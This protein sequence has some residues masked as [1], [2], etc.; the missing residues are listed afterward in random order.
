MSKPTAQAA[1]IT[2]QQQLIAARASSDRVVECEALGS[3]GVV[4]YQGEQWQDA[5][6]TCT[7]YLNLAKR[8]G[9]QWQEGIA[10]YYLGYS[11][12]AIGELAQAVDAFCAA[13]LLSR[14]FG[15][16]DVFLPVWEQLN[17]IVE[18]YLSKKEFP[19]A[20][21]LTQWQLETAQKWDNLALQGWLW[22]K[23]GKVHYNSGNYPEAIAAHREMLAIAEALSDNRLKN[24]TWAWLGCS[25]RE[26]GELEPALTYFEKR[27]DVVQELQ[28]RVAQRETLDWLISIY[29]QLKRYEQAIDCYDK[30]LRLLREVS[31]TIAEQNGVY[32]LAR[33]QFYRQQYQ[34]AISGF[35]QALNLAVGLA[36]NQ[37]KIANANYMLGR[38]YQALGQKETAIAAYQPAVESYLELGIQNWAAS[39]LDYLV[40]LYRELQEYEKGINC[41]Q[42][43]LELALKTGDRVA[44]P[45]ILYGIGNLYDDKKEDVQAIDYYQQALILAQALEQGHNQANACYMLGQVYARLKQKEEAIKYSQQAVSLYLELGVNEWA[46]KGLRFLSD[47]YRE[48]QQTEKGINCQQQRLKLAQDINDE[49][50]V[51]N[52]WYNLGCLYRDQHQDE[53]AI[54]ALSQALTLAQILKQQYKTANAHYLLGSTYQRLGQIT[55]AI[56][57][58]G[59]ALKLYEE[60]NTPKWAEKSSVKLRTLEAQQNL[61]WGDSQSLA[62]NSH[63]Q[64]LEFLEELLNSDGR[65]EILSRLLQANLAKLDN[66]F[67]QLIVN[68][69]NKLKAIETKTAQKIGDTIFDISES[70]F[71]LPL[72]ERATNLEISIACYEGLL[73]I[74]TSHTS[75]GAYTQNSLGIAYLERIRGQEAENVEKA[76]V[77]FN[78]ALEAYPRETFPEKWAM[79]TMN[80]GKAYSDRIRGERKENQ[81]RSISYYNTAVV[82]LT[83][84]KFSQYWAITQM[85]LGCIYRSHIRGEKAENVER[86]ISYYNTAVVVL[87]REKFPQ[88]WAITQMNLGSAYRKRIRGEKAENVERAISYY[89]TAVVVLTREKFPQ[90]WAM[91]QRNLGSAYR[92]RIRGEKVK[93]LEIAIAYYEAALKVFTHQSFPQKHAET[94]FSLAIG[95]YNTQRWSEAY[96]AL[97][98]SIETVDYLRGEICS[99]DEVKRK[100]NQEWNDHYLMMVQVCIKLQCYHKALEYADRSKARNLIESIASR[101]LYPQGIPEPTRQ[102][103]QQL[104]Q[105][106]YQENQRLAQDPNPDYTHITQLR[107][108]F[109]QK[110]PYKPLEFE[111]IQ[112]L[113]DQ[114]TAILEWYILDN[115]FLT[116]ILTPQTLDFWQSTSEDFINLI[117]WGNAY[118]ND[119]YTD[120]PQWQAKLPQRLTTLSDI[121]HLSHLLTTLFKQ[122]PTCKKLILIPH[123]SLHLLPLHALPVICRD[124]GASLGDEGAS[125]APLQEWFPK[126][127]N[128]VPNC[129]LLQQAQNRNSPEF[130][131]LFAIQNP[132]EDLIF[133]D[134]EV[135]TIRNIFPKDKRT[136]LSRKNATKTA[137]FTPGKNLT[138]ANNLYFSCHGA[139]NLNSPLDSGLQLADDVLTLAEIITSLNLSQ[140]SL[141]T[142]AACETGQVAIDTTDEYISLSSGFI[143]AGSPSVIVT[144]WSVNQISTALLLIKTYEILHQHPGKLAIALKT[145]QMWLRDT[146]VRGFQQWAQHSPIFSDSWRPQLQA[147][148]QNMGENKKQG[149]DSHPYQS[150]YH[151]AAFCVV[152]EGEQTLT[153]VK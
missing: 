114:D 138:Q 19:P 65:E 68:F 108:E 104:R 128:Y 151:W 28:D 13:Y 118:L 49:T 26:L 47:L 27:W 30:Q 83:R 105:A 122:F 5:I 15:N 112:S 126:G 95:Y 48:L 75:Q 103:L 110:S 20:Y 53:Q 33:L 152:G 82:V 98:Q 87:T 88:Y 109:Q 130:K 74:F 52:S 137:L 111:Q 4:Y 135:E 8:L 77:A 11:Y 31:D 100:F 92:K 35:A 36:D 60:T 140:C 144:Q 22:E 79:I 24:L 131:R 73:N 41:Q 71:I 37:E 133:A 45:S 42:Q 149:W 147:F 91:L 150:P 21:R 39:G 106:I 58:Y 25:Y 1:I 46:L 64:Y 115:Q 43:R 136:T 139:F 127:V 96:D 63:P 120:K 101:D 9:H 62:K 84:E 2:L 93:N 146:T 50:Q 85:N 23:L 97:A 94:L 10:Y 90:Y 56:D 7:D 142:L 6:A 153:H 86:A 132:T 38:C 80:L 29:T 51:Q 123:L 59:Q 124:E 99:R 102:R 134:L 44:E 121:L 119:Y 141:V 66:I 12:R 116:F 17:E 61:L 34:A 148:F 143:L 72:G 69:C 32:N 125:L 18:V 107:E 70:I 57:Q 3:L 76:I 40:N 145:A 14:Q 89:N 113:L 16:Q 129:Q 55:D 78:A 117:E 81:Q 54:A 67:L